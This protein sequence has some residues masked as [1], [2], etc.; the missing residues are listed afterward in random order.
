MEFVFCEMFLKKNTRD[1][2]NVVIKKMKH[3]P[4]TVIVVCDIKPP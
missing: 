4:K 1:A 3:I 2:P